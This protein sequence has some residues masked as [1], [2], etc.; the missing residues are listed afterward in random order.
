MET[1]RYTDTKAA[2][3]EPAALVLLSAG[4]TYV[5]RKIQFAG[6]CFYRGYKTVANVDVAW[7]DDKEIYHQYT[8][9]GEI[10]DDQP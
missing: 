2:G 8:K 9:G 5:Q 7:Y 1:N 6:L 3:N 4:R 10:N